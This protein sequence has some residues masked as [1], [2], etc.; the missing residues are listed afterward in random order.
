MIWK[1]NRREL[2]LS[3]CVL[4]GILNTT[5]DSFSDGGKYLEIEDAL[6]QAEKL[7]EEGASI[8][9]VGGESTRPGSGRVDVEDEIARTV[10]VIGAITK[11][12]D[13]PI[14]IDTSKAAVAR[15]AIDNGAEIIN[16]ISGLRFDPAIGEIAAETG[17]GIVLMHLRGEF[18]TMHQQDPLEDIVEELTVGFNESLDRAYSAGI[19]SE[20][21]CLDPGIGFSKT[22]E[23]NIEILGKLSTITN[24]F[25]E[26]PLLIGTSRK[27]FIGKLLGDVPVEERVSATV[28]T[29]VAAIAAGAKI[30]RVHDIKPNLDALKIANAILES[31]N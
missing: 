13:I 3:S 27:S 17:V 14:S 5:P 9:D 23:Q 2:D 12:F 1:T 8:I 22:F 21:I 20:A 19:K 30:I 6:R 24:R 31:G 16:D 18:E 25:I 4:M 10:P 7:I 28:A 11:R 15:V 29:T 26:Y